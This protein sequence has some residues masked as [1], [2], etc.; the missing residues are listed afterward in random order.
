LEDA[1]VELNGNVMVLADLLEKR[2]FEKDRYDVIW[3]TTFDEWLHHENEDDEE[4]EDEE[5][6]KTITD[7]MVSPEEKERR[8]QKWQ[9][10]L[11]S[12]N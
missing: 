7:I 1:V 10:F 9:T 6:P 3:T 8:D 4:E 12:L 2:K 11:D 5:E